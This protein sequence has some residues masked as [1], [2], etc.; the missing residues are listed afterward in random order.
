MSDSRCLEQEY[1]FVLHFSLDAASAA[2]EKEDA[3]GEMDVG[4][5]PQ[6]YACG[7]FCAFTPARSRGKAS[8]FDQVGRNPFTER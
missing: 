8:S 2:A 5:I 1:P 4:I 3:I 7:N 6:E